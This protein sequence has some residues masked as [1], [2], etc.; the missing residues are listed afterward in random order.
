MAHQGVVGWMSLVADRARGHRARGGPA[1][2]AIPVGSAAPQVPG[3]LVG[4]A[5]VVPMLATVV[6]RCIGVTS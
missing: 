2:A 3:P 5:D 4:R 6:S 1:T